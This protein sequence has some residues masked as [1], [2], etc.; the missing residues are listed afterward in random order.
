MGRVSFCFLSILVGLLLVGIRLDSVKK[1]KL[2]L[3]LFF[4]SRKENKQT[5]ERLSK[6]EEEVSKNVTKK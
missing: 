3:I 4:N 5:V 1:N 6:Q 2:Y